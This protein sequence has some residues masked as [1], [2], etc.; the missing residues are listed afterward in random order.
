MNTKQIEI[1]YFE[2]DLSLGITNDNMNSLR[3]L[4][5]SNVRCIKNLCIR[6]MIFDCGFNLNQILE[7]LHE[8]NIEVGN[9]DI[10]AEM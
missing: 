9:I 2:I 7:L 3:R 8:E 4:L 6:G 1:N 10:K 5:K